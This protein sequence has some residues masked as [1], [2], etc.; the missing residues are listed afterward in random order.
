M[1][2]L[3][4][5]CQSTDGPHTM[6][7]GNVVDFQRH[8]VKQFESKQTCTITQGLIFEKPPGLTQYY[9]CEPTPPIK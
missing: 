5:A 1:L 3:A 2:L 7:Y 8:P 9:A 6:I 4:A